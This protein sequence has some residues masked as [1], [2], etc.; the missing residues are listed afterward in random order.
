MKMRWTVAFLTTLIGVL[1]FTQRAEAAYS[2]VSTTTTTIGPFTRTVWV[3][4]DGASSFEQF[5]MYR[6]KKTNPSTP[7]KPVMLL[8]SIIGGFREYEVSWSA[9]YNDSFVGRLA[10]AGYDVWG[11]SQR[12]DGLTSNTCEASP[13]PCGPMAAWGIA[14]ILADVAYVRTQVAAVHGLVKPAAGGMSMGAALG[15]AAANAAPNDYAGVI[16]V[17]GGVYQTDLVARAYAGN[18]CTYAQT[19]LNNGSYYDASP[20]S[21]IGLAKQYLASPSLQN[22]ILFRSTLTTPAPSPFSFRP[23][24]VIND[25]NP[26]TLTYAD[27]GFAAKSVASY[28]DYLSVRTLRDM[29]CSLAGSDTFLFSNLGSFSGPTFAHVAGKGFGP[30]V[31]DTA[32]LTGGTVT[33][34]SYPLYGHRDADWSA[35]YATVLDTPLLAWLAV[36]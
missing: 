7:G 5:K 23:G 4:Q 11:L 3:V 1:F 19:Q 2:V 28:N 10:I 33:T 30:I 20:Q 9:A 26:T 34:Y 36:L 29:Q 32:A 17:D 18:W 25:G 13:S 15:F 22:A 24:Y 35:T 6:V 27:L 12:T 8:P 14:T 31:T 21:Q 16:A